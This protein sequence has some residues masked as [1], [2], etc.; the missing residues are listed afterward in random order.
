MPVID[1]KDINREK[2][3]INI[4]EQNIDNIKIITTNNEN[5]ELIY[6]NFNIKLDNFSNEEKYYLGILIKLFTKVST[7]NFN[8]ED[9]NNLIDTYTGY[10]STTVKVVGDNAYLRFTFKT[11]KNNFEKSMSILKE[12]LFNTKFDDYNR[13]KNIL[14]ELKI[15]SN[16][17]ILNSGHT[18]ALTRAMANMSL[19]RN[20]SNYISANGISFNMFLNELVS[21]YDEVKEKLISN[22]IIIYNK[23]LNNKNIFFDYSSN[24]INQKECNIQIKR[25][26]LE[27]SEKQVN[28]DNKNIVK[29]MNIDSFDRK[30]NKEGFLINSDI[31]FVA[32]AGRFDK[33]KFSGV[34]QLIKTIL[35][36]DYLWTNIRVIGGAYGMGV[37]VD[38]EGFIGFTTYRDP[39]LKKSDIVFKNIIDYLKNLEIDDKLLL[40]YK[41]GTIGSIDTP[42]NQVL[43]HE[44]NINYYLLNISNEILNKNRCEIID[45]NLSDIKNNILIFDDVINTCEVCSLISKKCE[46]EGKN[47]YKNIKDLFYNE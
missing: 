9:L 20:F 35:T 22:L 43:F 2:N 44:T 18:A 46:R 40:K 21:K 41:I 23:I 13:I 31:N 45:S 39:N 3:I 1:L 37:V 24:L 8:Y 47:Y 25:F 38:R 27:F 16:L 11:L 34:L 12:V 14:F 17:S 32:R 4:N 26:I 29:I 7:K 6:F 5:D 28:G 33:N 36:Y 42:L 15:E 19:A 30:H 10:F